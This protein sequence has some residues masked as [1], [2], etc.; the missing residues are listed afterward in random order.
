MVKAGELN[1]F[2]DEGS[3][4]EGTVSFQET[5]RVDGKIKGSVVSEK[6]LIVGPSG[7][8]EGE[9]RVGVCKVSGTV[10][11]SIVASGKVFIHRGG[12]IFADI[13]TPS[14]IIEE[15]AIF[16]GQCKMDSSRDTGVNITP[17]RDQK[18]R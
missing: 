4:V 1:G 9:I 14:L 12:K 5:L 10:M 15:G 8:I 18:I 13:E 2:L 7:I 16:Q 11:G 17:I 6:D 3:L